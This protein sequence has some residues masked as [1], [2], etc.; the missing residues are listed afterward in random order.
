MLYE[1]TLTIRP[2]M[3]RMEAN[4]QY[5]FLYEHLRKILDKFKCSMI[6][7][8]TSE[9]NVHYHG[10]IEL[11]DFQHRDSLFNKLRNYHKWFGRKTC[12]QLVDEPKYDE[13]MRKDIQKTKLLIEH[14]IVMDSFNIFGRDL[15]NIDEYFA[16]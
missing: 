12:T 13:Y 16:E 2:M 6:A 11:K 1:L 10:K 14:P 5:K 3:Y 4:E 8:L 7:E 15:R 9:N